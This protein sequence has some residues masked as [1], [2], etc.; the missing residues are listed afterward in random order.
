M[1][2]YP[3]ERVLKD[4]VIDTPKETFC[5]ERGGGCTAHVGGVLKVLLVY[6]KQLI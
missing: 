5:H 3:A 6:R 4:T 1:A 2:A